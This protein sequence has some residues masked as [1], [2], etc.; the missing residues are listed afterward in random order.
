MKIVDF[1]ADWCGPC[2]AMKPTLDSM[3]EKGFP[4]EKVN[5]DENREIAAQYGIRSIPT[6]LFIDENDN[7]VDKLVGVVS[8]AAIISK[9]EAL[10]S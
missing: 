5:V 10:Q 2:K 6:I 7:A 9:W 3:I 4:I 1:Y 8:E